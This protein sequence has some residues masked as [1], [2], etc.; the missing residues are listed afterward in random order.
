MEKISYFKVYD[1][2]RI[3]GAKKYLITCEGVGMRE[4]SNSLH[5]AKK[6]CDALNNYANT[7]A[8]E[9]DIKTY[10]ERQTDS[11]YTVVYES[12]QK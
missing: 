6:V 7:I 11:I 10:N 2:N 12:Y 1:T 5:E 4:H 3:A 9:N 8:T